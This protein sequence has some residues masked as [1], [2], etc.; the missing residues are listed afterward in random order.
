MIDEA[1]PDRAR[2]E[3]LFLEGMRHEIDFWTV[4]L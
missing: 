1:R 2:A 4:P 3:T